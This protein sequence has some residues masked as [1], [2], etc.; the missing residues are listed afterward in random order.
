MTTRNAA[1]VTP[2]SVHVITI[3]RVNG[4]GPGHPNVFMP[5]SYTVS[6]APLRVLFSDVFLRNP[7]GAERDFVITAANLCQYAATVWRII[8]S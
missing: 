7:V 2:R 4:V 6:N 3:S 8:L 1:I 5:G